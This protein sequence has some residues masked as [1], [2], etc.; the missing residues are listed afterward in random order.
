MDVVHKLMRSR[1]IYITFLIFFLQFFGV[2]VIVTGTDAHEV[3]EVRIGTR[4]WCAQE[5]LST[6]C[7]IM[8][9]YLNFITIFLHMCRCCC[10]QWHRAH[11]ACVGITDDA[12]RAVWQS[13]LELPGRLVL[14]GI[15]F[16]RPQLFT[17]LFTVWGCHCKIYL[18]RWDFHVWVPSK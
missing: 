4:Q 17:V 5:S 13:E 10:Q 3:C 7:E 6:W 12:H 8:R 16:W 2:I 9:I 1:Y 11:E 15:I 14:T 18:T